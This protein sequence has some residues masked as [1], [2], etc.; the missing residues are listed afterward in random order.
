LLVI[1]LFFLIVVCSFA[2]TPSELASIVT[3]PVFGNSSHFLVWDYGGAVITDAFWE[4]A[5][6]FHQDS[7]V[8]PLN[9]LLDSLTTNPN[10]D[11]YKILHDISIPFGGA[12]GDSVGLFP[13]AYLGR[14]GYYN[15][16]PDAKYDNTTD[17][18][19]AEIV[20]NKYILGWP[21]HISDGTIS[22]TSGWTGEPSGSQFL[23]D[24]DMYMGLTL[25]SRVAVLQKNSTLANIA[26]KM[27]VTFASHSRDDTSSLYWHGFNNAD[28]HHSC[29]KWG[30]GNG[31]IMM[32]HIEVLKAL[33][34]T[35]N[36][37]YYSQVVSIL[38]EHSKGLMNV[39][40]SNGLWHQVL[41]Q[42]STY[43]ETSSTA[44]YL[45]SLA[46]GINGGWLDKSV[47][48]PVVEKA[49]SGLQTTISNEGIVSGVCEGT[50]VGTTVQ[51]YEQ[52]ST[53]YLSSSP[54]LGSVFKS[55]S[56]YARYSNS[57]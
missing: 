3:K 21:H 35:S 5:D 26:G 29:C 13:I 27:Q 7:L 10:Q 55:I 20:S 47:F 16:H 43:L 52:R 51:F 1:C 44:M 11:G 23:W 14:V 18:K 2:P 39:Q 4:Y 24:D 57:K 6:Y 32:S 30:R 22:R 15:N 45:W 40:S 49:W 36:T 33:K 54:G 38:Q 34:A 31:W 46:E 12:V 53:A 42:D 8:T 19:I 9:N 50:G 25:I 48:G 28:Q 17:L 41:D 56:A 37:Q